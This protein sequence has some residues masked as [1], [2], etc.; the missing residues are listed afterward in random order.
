MLVI[1]R[2][3]GEEIVIGGNIRIMVVRVQGDKVRLGIVAPQE[4]KVLRAE[5][6]GMEPENDDDKSEAA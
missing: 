6:V 1:T 4:V 5:L 2:K 3:S